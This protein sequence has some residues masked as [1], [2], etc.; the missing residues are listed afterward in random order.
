M[1]RK[2]RTQRDLQVAEG[3]EETVAYQLVEVCFQCESCI[4]LLACSSRV[5]PLPAGGMHDVSTA[6]G[7]NPLRQVRVHEQRV[8]ML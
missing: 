6:S 3:A 7:M 5:V 8:V 4:C 2:T 1:H